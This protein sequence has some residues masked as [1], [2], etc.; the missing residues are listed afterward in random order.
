MGQHGELS[1]LDGTEPLPRSPYA[2]RNIEPT[3]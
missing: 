2:A 3:K 1:P